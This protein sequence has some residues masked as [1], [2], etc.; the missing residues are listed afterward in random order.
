MERRE[1]DL[2][3]RWFVSLGVDDPVWHHST[4]SKNRDRLLEGKISAKFI[5]AVLAQPKVKR[6]LSRITSRRS[7]R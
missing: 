7:A 2:L 6:L 1:F 4:S 3:F 5:S